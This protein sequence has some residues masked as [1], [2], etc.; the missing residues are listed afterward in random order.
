MEPKLWR[1]IIINLIE[2]LYNWIRSIFVISC[3]MCAAIVCACIVCVSV[4]SQK[5]IFHMYLS[6]YDRS[7]STAKKNILLIL[8][9]ANRLRSRCSYAHFWFKHSVCVSVWVWVCSCPVCGMVVHSLE[10]AIY[11]N[12]HTTFRYIA[13]NVNLFNLFMCEKCEF[14]FFKSEIF[15]FNSIFFIICKY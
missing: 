5:S 14:F 9:E 11:S 15:F 13:E 10:L 12:I 1:I 6:N 3:W 2:I 8:K 7:E 4:H